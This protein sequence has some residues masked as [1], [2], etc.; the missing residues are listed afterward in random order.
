MDKE[1]G[2]VSVVI[3][4]YCCS[5]T[6]D[7]AVSS[8]YVQTIRPHEVILVD[9]CSPD[10][11]LSN[12]YE[13]QASYPPGWIKIITL[14]TNSGP[15]SA[16][17]AGWN[18]STQH[19]VAFLDADDSWH[20]QKIEVQL[21][22]MRANPSV[23]LTGHK[24]EVLGGTKAHSISPILNPPQ[25]KEVKPAHLLL[26]NIFQTPT[27]MVR[28]DLDFRMI[29]GKRYSE[30]YHLWLKTILSGRKGYFIDYPMAYLY[31]AEYGASGLSGN[32][33]E[34]EKGEIDTF[35]RL[36]KDKEIKI[37]QLTKSVAFSLIKYFRRAIIVKLRKATPTANK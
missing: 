18:A 26:K 14:G 15:G 11:T 1:L 34:L 25:W 36:Y 30:D 28:N 13:L 5:E 4:C 19:Y 8:V 17:N 16:R 31:K 24:C 29:E 20:P 2:E 32:L 33:W 21:S 6:I 37:T 35:F 27:V 7:R 22:W 12:L 9:D 3:P 23:S 10:E